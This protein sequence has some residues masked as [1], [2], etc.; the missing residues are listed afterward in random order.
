MRR[1]PEEQNDGQNDRG[2]REAGRDRR[3]ACK[4]REASGQAADDDVPGA[5]LLEPDGVDDAVD[6]GAEKDVERDMRIEQPCRAAD[7]DREDCADRDEPGPPV[8][9]RKSVV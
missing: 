7:G 2:G 6:E 9:D 8:L 1:R 4:H 5:A 3:G